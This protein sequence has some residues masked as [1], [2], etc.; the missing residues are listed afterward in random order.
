MAVTE[1]HEQTRRALGGRVADG[2]AAE[3][4][5]RSYRSGTSINE[6]NSHD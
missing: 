6:R 3:S 5:T 1:R 2:V 4:S